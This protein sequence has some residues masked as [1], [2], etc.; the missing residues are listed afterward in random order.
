M[1]LE[2]LPCPSNDAVTLRTVA[3]ASSRTLLGLTVSLILLPLRVESSSRMVSSA[4]WTVNPFAV[5]VTFR[6]SSSSALSSPVTVT[7]RLP[8]P[9]DSPSGM[10]TVAV[11]L[12]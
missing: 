11:A 3:P 4:G 7:L 10:I 2:A 1:L 8:D 12:E 9:L 6:V 5:P